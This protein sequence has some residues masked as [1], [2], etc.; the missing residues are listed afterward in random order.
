MQLI[1]ENK[2]GSLMLNKETGEFVGYLSN[3]KMKTKPTPNYIKCKER[4][5]IHHRDMVYEGSYKTVYLFDDVSGNHGEILTYNDEYF[6]KSEDG[7]YLEKFNGKPKNIFKTKKD[8]ETVLKLDRD[9][10]WHDDQAWRAR[11]EIDKLRL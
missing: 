9:A 1:E 7:E 5:S 6:V 10:D 2:Y 4:M 11:Q 3:P 8:L